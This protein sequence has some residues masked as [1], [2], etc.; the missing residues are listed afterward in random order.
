LEASVPA[1]AIALLPSHNIEVVYRPLATPLL[2]VF[3]IFIL[4]STLRLKLWISV[5]SGS[6]AAFSYAGAALYLG[7]RPPITGARAPTAQSAVMLN[8]VTLLVSGLIA[9]TITKEIRKHVLA[10]LREAETKRKLEA[11]QHDLQVAGSIQQS[12]LPAVPPQIAGFEI[13][14]W[15]QPADETGGDYFDW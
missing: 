11:V 15:N 4:L 7:W 3:G 14:G 2:L 9:G 13:A 8:T 1:W 10:A 5:L 6:V 12:L